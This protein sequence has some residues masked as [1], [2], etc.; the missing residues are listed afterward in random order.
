M[1]NNLKNRFLQ[2][3][4]KM[5]EVF[6]YNTS[7]IDWCEPNYVVNSYIAEFWNVVSSLYFFVIA[8][9][10]YMS[11]KAEYEPKLT[12]IWLLIILIGLGSILFHGT[13]SVAGQVMDEMSILIF[14]LYSFAITTR[15]SIWNSRI[16]NVVLSKIFFTLSIILSIMLCIQNPFFSHALTM[17]FIPT[18][19][20][21]YLRTYVPNYRSLFYTKSK[22]ST[23]HK[24]FIISM[25]W[26]VFAMIVW[27]CERSMCKYVKKFEKSFGF[28]I[29]LHA[30]W[31][32]FISNAL[33]GFFM[34]AFI[35]RTIIEGK[36]IKIN[37]YYNSM[38][39]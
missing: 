6:G 16:R 36:K 23:E 39:V 34:V 15:K 12:F 30:L 5:L 3:F 13:L 21:G 29:H 33:W 32:L 8:C 11:Y 9:W 14:I 37:G 38:N 27:C 24:I 7:P 1:A 35:K 28:H 19:T 4:I 31:H 25:V 2:F 26:F 18:T 22:I 17:F 10:G 20:Y